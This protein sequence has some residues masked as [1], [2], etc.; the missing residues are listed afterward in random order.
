MKI[1][2][3]IFDS[4]YLIEAEQRDDSRGTMSVFF[5]KNQMAEL[6]DGFEISEQRLYRM[7]RK[8]TFFGIH[9]QKPGKAKGKL[10]SVVQGRA[11]DFI[12][13]LREGSPTFKQYKSFELNADTPRLVYLPAGF[14]H[15]FF[16]LEENTIQVFAIDALA[17]KDSSGIISY[18]DPEINLQLLAEDS[19]IIISDYDKNAG[20]KI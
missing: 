18:K 11:L 19:Q 5:N 9:Y 12:V 8:N 6:L 14:G 13:D 17:G 2:E 3:T 4:C 10:I 20:V 7:P 15:G 1:I 16:T